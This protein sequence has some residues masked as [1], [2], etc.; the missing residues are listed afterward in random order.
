MKEEKEA[1]RKIKYASRL[2]VILAGITVIFAI[3]CIMFPEMANNIIKQKY[4][5]MDLKSFDPKI[6]LISS[7]IIEAV[8]Y[9]WYFW[10]SIRVAK[11]KSEGN[12]LFIVL[13]ISAIGAC[14]SLYDRL[15][16]TTLLGFFVDVLIL[17][18]LYRIRVE[19]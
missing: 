13:I 1:K 11:E 4:A 8:I 16:I 19:D 12:V 9:I 10:L 17:Q 6:M 14:L 15:D 2:Y 7:Y 18:S 3:F 5:H